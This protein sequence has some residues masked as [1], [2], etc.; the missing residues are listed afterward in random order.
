MRRGRGDR[1]VPER[2]HGE[3]A[4]GRL[5]TAAEGASGHH[6]LAGFTVHETADRFGGMCQ[7]L[8]AGRVRGL[9]CTPSTTRLLDV[10]SATPTARPIT[11]AADAAPLAIVNGSRT[12]TGTG[13][14]VS[15]TRSVASP[16]AAA[17]TNAS[18]AGPSL[19]HTSRYPSRSAS[20]A[21]RNGSSTGL[22]SSRA[23]ATTVKSM[24]FTEL[25]TSRWYG[26]RVR[27]SP[28][29]GPATVACPSSGHRTGVTS[30]VLKPSWP[31]RQAPPGSAIEII[32]T[33]HRCL[34]LHA[35]T[36]EGAGWGTAERGDYKRLMPQRV[37]KL[38]WINPKTLWPAGTGVLASWFGDPT[39][40]TRDRWVEQ[41]TAA[42]AAPADKVVR[43]DDP[44]RFSFMVIGDTGEGD[45]PQ[46]AVVPGFLKAGQ[47]SRFAVLA[48]DVVYP[49]GTADDYGAKFHRP[50][51]DYQAPIYAKVSDGGGTEPNFSGYWI[52]FDDH[53]TEVEGLEPRDEQQPVDRR[54]PMLASRLLRA[55]APALPSTWSRRDG[56][57]RI[58][59]LRHNEPGGR[60]VPR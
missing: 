22:S 8:A 6:R 9:P 2:R 7:C 51:K 3:Q 14:T 24:H 33:V 41:R 20:A 44:D 18:Q 40:R 17:R 11:A 30:R 48:S 13:P 47:D 25:A 42:G 34:T 49:V 19:A 10:P 55:L 26:R 31:W 43:R 53:S 50:Y 37:E 15:V 56:P 58:A 46:Y 54:S 5:L 32:V 35:D 45:D 29:Q 36:A 38:S 4:A 12:E 57:G 52:R 1:T 28:I 21:T 39:G 27:A 23:A 60:G 59:A 16:I